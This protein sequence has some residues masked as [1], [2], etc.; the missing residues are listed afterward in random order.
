MKNTNDT[1]ER[2]DN[3]N[4]SYIYGKDDCITKNYEAEVY[5]DNE[6]NFPLID[7]TPTCS[8]KASIDIENNNIDD[9]IPD[10][11]KWLVDNFNVSSYLFEY[12]QKSTEI[13]RKYSTKEQSISRIP[14]GQSDYIYTTHSFSFIN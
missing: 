8:T 9:T 5:G 11:E 3:V 4:G 12:R 7:E 13:I 14:W 2:D 10:E 1:E 6:S